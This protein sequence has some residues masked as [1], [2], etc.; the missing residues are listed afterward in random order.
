M[1]AGEKEVS[2]EAREVEGDCLLRNFERSLRR[3]RCGSRC[4]KDGNQDM[5]R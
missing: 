3:I 5:G 4:G 1:S 2:R